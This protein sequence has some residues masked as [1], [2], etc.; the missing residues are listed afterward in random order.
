MTLVLVSCCIPIPGGSYHL[1]FLTRRIVLHLAMLLQSPHVCSILLNKTTGF[2]QNVTFYMTIRI[3]LPAQIQ[4]HSSPSPMPYC[5]PG[6]NKRKIFAS[7]D[8]PPFQMSAKQGL[9][10]CYLWS[11]QKK[12]Q[13]KECHIPTAWKE[14]VSFDAPH[15]H[16][17]PQLPCKQPL[18]RSARNKDS[19][20]KVAIWLH[21]SVLWQHLMTKSWWQHSVWPFVTL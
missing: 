9:S 12:L 21:D 7:L 17:A 13:T 4:G 19:Y 3:V 2:L 18:Q 14:S 1:L 15:L 16:P 8:C 10:R 6:A 5:G 11:Q 20:D